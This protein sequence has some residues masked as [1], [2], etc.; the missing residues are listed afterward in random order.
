MKDKHNEHSVSTHTDSEFLCSIIE[1]QE[2]QITSL[3]TKIDTLSGYLSDI[4]GEL[5][6]ARLKAS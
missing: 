4:H 5:S 3:Q 1:E 2:K 6:Q